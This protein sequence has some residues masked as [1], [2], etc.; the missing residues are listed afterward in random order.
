[1][2][3]WKKVSQ[4]YCEGVSWL[5]AEAVSLGPAAC[6]QL[7]GAVVEIKY[8]DDMGPW[9]CQHLPAC[10][11][12]MLSRMLWLCCHHLF[13]ERALADLKVLHAADQEGSRM[14]ATHLSA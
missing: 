3:P 9:P 5:Q 2:R 4:V 1:M 8:W 7:V 6:Q 13:S 12:R 14:G 10:S 11:N